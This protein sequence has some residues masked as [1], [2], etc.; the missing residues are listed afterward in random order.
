LVTGTRCCL[1]ELD[2]YQ[3]MHVVALHMRL[4]S[5][6]DKVRPVDSMQVGYHATVSMY[7]SSI[8]SGVV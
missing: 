1:V 4:D 2:K 3:D 6:G 7:S 8:G 5:V